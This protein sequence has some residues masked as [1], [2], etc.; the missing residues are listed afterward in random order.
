M[1]TA[2]PEPIGLWEETDVFPKEGFAARLL[3]KRIKS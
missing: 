2:I 3:R 1:L